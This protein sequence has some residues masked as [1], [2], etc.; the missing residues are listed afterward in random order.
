MGGAAGAS[1]DRVKEGF[2]REVASVKAPARIEPVAPL[3]LSCESG[4]RRSTIEYPCAAPIW[5]L[6]NLLDEH[7]LNALAFGMLAKLVDNQIV[8]ADG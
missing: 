3:D 2:R 4:T 6:R 1:F 7:V 8:R 5:R